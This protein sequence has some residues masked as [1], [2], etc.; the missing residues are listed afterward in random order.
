MRWYNEFYLTNK[1][2]IL[3]T[4]IKETFVYEFISPNQSQSSTY[5]EYH[6]CTLIPPL[7]SLLRHVS[8]LLQT[9]NDTH[10]VILS[11]WSHFPQL[12]PLGFDVPTPNSVLT[13]LGI[14]Q[15]TPINFNFRS[16]CLVGNRW[17]STYFLHL[18]KHPLCGFFFFFIESATLVLD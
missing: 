10:H 6:M 12:L 11:V 5:C 2:N 15:F 1:E 4:Y 18:L 16:Y 8:P 13:V 3:D 17:W 9:F 7:P 14:I